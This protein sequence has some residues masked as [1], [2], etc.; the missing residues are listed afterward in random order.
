M[1]LWLLGTIVSGLNYSL[2]PLL[3]LKYNIYLNSLNPKSL[4][5]DGS[6][7]DFRTMLEK[8]KYAKNVNDEDG[9][10][11]GSLKKVDRP[12]GDSDD[13]DK[14]VNKFVSVSYLFCQIVWISIW[15]MRFDRK[16]ILICKIYYDFDWG[17][18]TR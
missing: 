17:N 14:K 16:S 6:G 2:L 18:H 11:W 12:D 15:T 8:K 4:N 7:M 13:P 3:L 10:D 5:S 9:P 1:K